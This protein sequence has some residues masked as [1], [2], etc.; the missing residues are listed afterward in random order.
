[1]LTV[2]FFLVVAAFIVTIASAIGKAPLWVAVLLIVLVL[3][4]K[5][6]GGA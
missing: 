1:M 5:L 2:D 6:L 4:L 3:L